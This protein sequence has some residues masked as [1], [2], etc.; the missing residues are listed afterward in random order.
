MFSSAPKKDRHFPNVWGLFY[1]ATTLSSV[2]SYKFS[3]VDKN[4]SSLKKFDSF[5]AP[6]LLLP[7]MVN[8]SKSWKKEEG[9]DLKINATGKLHNSFLGGLDTHA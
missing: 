3:G 1:C 8:F 2:F 7:G 4:L 9:N 6:L 5:L